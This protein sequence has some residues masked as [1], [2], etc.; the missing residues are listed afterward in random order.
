MGKPPAMLRHHVIDLGEYPLNQ[1]W[2][3]QIIYFKS[4]IE[5]VVRGPSHLLRPET[6]ELQTIGDGETVKVYH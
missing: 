3:D 1:A 4:A 5:E 2:Q 6:F